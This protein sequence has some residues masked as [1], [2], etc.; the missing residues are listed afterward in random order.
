MFALPPVFFSP[1]VARFESQQ[2][3]FLFF[4]VVLLAGEGGMGEMKTL[5]ER[6]DACCWGRT[7]RNTHAPLFMRM[8]GSVLLFGA[9]TGG[10]SRARAGESIREERRKK[11]EG[12]FSAALYDRLTEPLFA[13]F[14]CFFLF[15]KNGQKK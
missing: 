13:I 11:D 10:K 7:M 9:Y 5:A 8:S 4:R 14:F 15:S 12:S 2:F 1:G 3:F 6:D